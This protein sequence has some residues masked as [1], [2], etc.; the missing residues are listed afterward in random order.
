MVW[1]AIP[2]MHSGVRHP[3]SQIPV[4]LGTASKSYPMKLKSKLYEL[5]PNLFHRLEDAFTRPADQ[6]SILQGVRT[7]RKGRPHVRIVLM[8]SPKN[9]QHF[10]ACEG[11]LESALALSLEIDPDVL[12][13]RTQPFE[14]PGGFGHPLV[15]DFAVRYIDHRYTIINVKPKDQLNLPS[16]EDRNH[17]VREALTMACIPYRIVTEL[18]LEHQPARSIREQL[19]KGAKVVLAPHGREQLLEVLGTRLVRVHDLRDQAIKL[20]L[21]PWSVEK[22]ALLGDITFPITAPLREPTVVGATHGTNHTSTDG[23]GTV[24]DVRVPI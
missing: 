3:M 2:G 5:P 15:C 14:I 23:W 7:F 20:N 12:A 11:R 1:P 13:F 9:D 18:E 16:V 21:S 8:P 22:L 10:I 17:R 24:R 6:A 19:R 4:G